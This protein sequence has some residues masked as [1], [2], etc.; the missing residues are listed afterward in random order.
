MGPQ[1]PA[2]AAPVVAIVGATGAVGVELIGCLERRR[3]PLAELRLFASA[4]SA[5]KALAFHGRALTVRELAEDSFNGVN[6]RAVFRRQR[7]LQTLC[8]DRGARRRHRGRQ[9]LGIPHGP[10]GAAGRAGDQPRGVARAPRHH[11]Q[12]QLR[13]DHLDHAAVAHTPREPHP[14]ADG[15]NLPGRLGRRRGRDARAA[16]VD[17]RP[18]RGTGV[19]ARRCCRTAT[20]SM[21]SATTP[22]STR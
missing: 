21:S 4:R 10:A 16:R 20:R 14:A 1:S 8:A 5:G 3:F 19:R 15:R 12:S 2:A 7:H 18:P 9:L 13:G 17:A 6:H 22:V 11:R